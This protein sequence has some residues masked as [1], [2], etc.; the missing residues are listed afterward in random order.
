[1]SRLRTVPGGGVVVALTFRAFVDDV[2]RFPSA[3]QLSAAVGLV[4]RE[5]RSAERRHRGHIT[6]AG[7]RELR[8]LLVQAAWACWRSKQ[9]ATLRAGVAQLAARLCADGPICITW[10]CDETNKSACG[11][12]NPQNGFPHAHTHDFTMELDYQ[13]PLIEEHEVQAIRRVE[14]DGCRP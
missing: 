11:S 3:S 9:S 13:Q 6:K 8:S 12:E 7:P 14:R 10:R 4:P 2:A 1:M 5:A